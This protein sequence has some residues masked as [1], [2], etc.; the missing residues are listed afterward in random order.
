M[1]PLNIVIP[2]VNNPAAMRF[3]GAAVVARRRTPECTSCKVSTTRRH[4]MTAFRTTNLILCRCAPIRKTCR[5]CDALL[6]T[7]G[8][9]GSKRYA[10]PAVDAPNSPEC[11][12]ELLQGVDEILDVFLI[13]DGM[14]FSPQSAEPQVEND[15]LRETSTYIFKTQPI[16]SHSPH[17]NARHFSPW[18][19]VQTDS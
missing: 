3:C 10:G 14:T 9:E 7:M 4:L 8:P 13:E 6:Q 15:V 11:H 17:F 16:F 18:L 19:D 12:D 5:V 2:A 1:L